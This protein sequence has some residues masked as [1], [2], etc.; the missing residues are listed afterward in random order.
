MVKKL[1]VGDW[2]GEV[3]PEPNLRRSLSAP[4]NQPLVHHDGSADLNQLHARTA[5]YSLSVAKATRPEIRAS[6]A[7]TMAAM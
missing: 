6:A 4:Q 2:E 1:N 5:C 7:A 3:D